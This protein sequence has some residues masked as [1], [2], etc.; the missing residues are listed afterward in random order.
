M[1][2]LQGVFM[3]GFGVSDQVMETL[4]ANKTICLRAFCIDM[5]L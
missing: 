1:V 4:F 5:A 3:S 2:W